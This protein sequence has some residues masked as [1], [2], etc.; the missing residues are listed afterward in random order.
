M[1]A[2]GRACTEIIVQIAS[3]EEAPRGVARTL[4]ENH[5]LHCAAKRLPAA[6]Q[7]NPS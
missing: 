2:E 7:P 6:N 5:L 1:L 3:V 4:V